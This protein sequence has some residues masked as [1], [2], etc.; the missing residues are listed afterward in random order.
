MNRMCCSKLWSAPIF[1][2]VLLGT[3]FSVLKCSTHN[4]LPLVVGKRVYHVLCGN[5]P[6]HAE[7]AGR[8]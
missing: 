3:V 6:N 2:M 1:S 7:I 4:R 8:S 5:P